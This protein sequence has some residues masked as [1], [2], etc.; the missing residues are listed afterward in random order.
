MWQVAWHFQSIMYVLVLTWTW[1]FQELLFVLSQHYVYKVCV[2]VFKDIQIRLIQVHTC[3]S[4]VS[5]GQMNITVFEL[6]PE[7]LPCLT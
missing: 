6:F 2:Y 4:K 7:L 1:K 3:E 5:L